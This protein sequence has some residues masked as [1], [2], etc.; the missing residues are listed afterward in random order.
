[1]VNSG[2]LR[3]LWAFLKTPFVTTLIGGL[4]IALSSHKWQSASAGYEMERARKQAL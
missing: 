1:M 3:K 4:V 2:F